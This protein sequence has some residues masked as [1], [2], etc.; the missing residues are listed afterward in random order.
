MAWKCPECGEVNKLGDL[1]KCLSCGYKIGEQEELANIVVEEI[2]V[3]SGNKNY[4]KYSK[5][6]M[7]AAILSSAGL[8]F[9]LLF[10]FFVDRNRHQNVFSYSYYLFPISMISSFSGIM[11][12]LFNLDPGDTLARTGLWLGIINFLIVGCFYLFVRLLIHI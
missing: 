9:L 11:T 6:G 7:Y 10:W 5:G 8:V 12:A 2:K 3:K 4:K 1:A